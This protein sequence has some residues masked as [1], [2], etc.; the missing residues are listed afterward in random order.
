MFTRV[1]D[2]AAEWTSEAVDERLD[3]SPGIWFDRCAYRLG[4]SADPQESA[5][6]GSNAVE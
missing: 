5:A 2:F 6:C 1:E 4:V 3:K